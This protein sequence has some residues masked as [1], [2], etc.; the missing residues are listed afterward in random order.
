[1]QPTLAPL[2]TKGAMNLCYCNITGS[3]R[4][5]MTPPFIGCVPI[6]RMRQLRFAIE[7]TLLRLLRLNDSHTCSDLLE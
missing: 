5:F 6:S 1:M 2:S 4:H 7:E 3:Q